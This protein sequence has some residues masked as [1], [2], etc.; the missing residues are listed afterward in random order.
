M[1]TIALLGATGSLGR[2]MG[3]QLSAAGQSYRAVSRSQMGLQV[4]FGA[5]PLAAPMLWEP[6]Q[7]LSILHALKGAETAVYLAGV[8]V[9]EFEKHI[10]LTRRVLEAADLAGLRRLLLVSSTWAYGLPQTGRVSEA[11]PLGAQ[12][13]KGR[14]R[15]TQEQMVLAAGSGGELQTA[16]LRVGDFYG[17]Y[18]EASYLW[19]AFKA[20]KNGTHAQL[21]SPADTAHEFVYVPDAAQTILNM[22]DTPAIWGAAWNLGG[23][24]VTSVRA[25]TEAIFGEARKPPNYEVPPAWK[26]RIVAMMNPYVREMREMQYLLSQPVLLEDSALDNALGGL[27]KTAY[28]VGIRE[29]LATVRYGR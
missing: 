11:H 28:P 14:I 25:M 18:V 21:M 26:M 24:G 17:P 7:P 20:A 16:V 15:L 10:A 23:T 19:S 6:E 22:L 9:W 1:T 3:R 13:A 8:P 12:T 2:A 27:K 29:T 5:D 4:R